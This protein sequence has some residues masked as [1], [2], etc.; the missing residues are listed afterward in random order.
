[1]F[2][3]LAENDIEAA[4]Y[5]DPYQQRSPYLSAEGDS[6]H[7]FIP[8]MPGEEGV[9]VRE[10]FFDN[11]TEEDFDRTMA[12]LDGVQQ[13]MGGIGNFFRKMKARRQARRE[14]KKASKHTRQLDRIAARGEAGTG[15]GGLFKGIGRLFGGGEVAPPGTPPIV[16]QTFPQYQQ[17]AGIV[18]KPP[19]NWTPIIIGGIALVVVG[20]LLRAQRKR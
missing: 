12:Y 2:L 20:G 13:G 18:P 16:G 8:G 5:Y 4:T 14:K 17:Q 1:M 7:V 10:D 11:L 3:E 15:I 9:Y 6:H 19:M